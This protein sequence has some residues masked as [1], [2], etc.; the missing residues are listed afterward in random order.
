[1]NEATVALLKLP[2]QNVVFSHSNTSCQRRLSE[3]KLHT[4]PL[5]PQSGDTTS[6]TRNRESE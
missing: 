2:R 6:C 4:I 1:M 3:E 5:K